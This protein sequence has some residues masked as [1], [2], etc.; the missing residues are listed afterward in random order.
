MAIVGM[1]SLKKKL[2]QYPAVCQGMVREALAAGAD[3]I[4]A[5]MR[6][7]CPKKK[8]ALARSI[9]WTWGKAPKG[10]AVIATAKTPT[11]DATITIYA[12]DAEAFYARF[13][14]FGVAAHKAGGLFEGAVI[15][16]IA[17]HPFFYPAYRAKRKRVKSRALRAMGKAA[18]QVA[19]RK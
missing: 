6:S 16:A 15:P 9:G 12:G 14:E 8:G 4:V 11:R 18:K 19:N 13:V 1:S 7:L 2:S 5:L 10:S 17:A 3:E